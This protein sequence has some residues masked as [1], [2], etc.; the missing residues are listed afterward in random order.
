MVSVL[1]N[2]HKPI[3]LPTLQPGGEGDH[4]GLRFL[5]DAIQAGENERNIAGAIWTIWTMFCSFLKKAD[6]FEQK[7]TPTWEHFEVCQ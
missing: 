3:S 7:N 6:H 5:P 4:R 2:Q 1:C